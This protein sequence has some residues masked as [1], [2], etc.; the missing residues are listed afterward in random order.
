[1]AMLVLATILMRKHLQGGAADVN[2]T[3]DLGYE[4]NF[5]RMHAPFEEFGVVVKL[6]RD[7]E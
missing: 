5:C 7:G 2:V 1:M 3:C 6:S 4:Q